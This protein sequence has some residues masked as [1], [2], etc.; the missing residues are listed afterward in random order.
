MVITCEAPSLV[1]SVRKVSLLPH[2]PAL[3]MHQVPLQS[4]II[5]TI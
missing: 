5:G 2:G 3:I 1:V 4:E